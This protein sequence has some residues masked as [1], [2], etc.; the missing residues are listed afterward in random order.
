VLHSTPVSFSVWYFKTNWCPIITPG[1]RSDD[2]EAM[3]EATGLVKEAA[4]K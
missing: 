4:C 2:G 3:V 1:I